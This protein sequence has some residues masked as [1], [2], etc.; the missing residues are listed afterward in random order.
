M[1]YLLLL[2]EVGGARAGAQGQPCVPF[3]AQKG[4]G[5]RV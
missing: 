2:N 4:L 3:S 5:F 1:F